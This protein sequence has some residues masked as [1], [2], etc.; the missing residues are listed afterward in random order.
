M[1]A[2]TTVSDVS[3]RMFVSGV[4]QFDGRGLT[5]NPRTRVSIGAGDQAMVGSRGGGGGFDAAEARCTDAVV[6]R[7][8]DR[9]T[10]SRAL[11][12]S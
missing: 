2:K 9:P 1:V 10:E 11:V 6:S 8:V 3:Q 12:M 4:T 7:V 5:W